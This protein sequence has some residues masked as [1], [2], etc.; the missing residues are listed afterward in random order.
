MFDTRA[1]TL[2]GAGTRFMESLQIQISLAGNALTVPMANVGERERA[3]ETERESER[4]SERASERERDTE[5]QRERGREKDRDREIERE[6][7]RE[8]EGEREKVSGILHARGHV[9]HV[10]A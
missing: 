1:L 9:A 8:G 7:G 4:A 10:R 2:L 5:R 3:R 6:G